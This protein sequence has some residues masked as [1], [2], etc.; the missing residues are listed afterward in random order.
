MPI[1]APE[2]S[3]FPPDLLDRPTIGDETDARWWALYSLPRREKQLMRRLKTHGLAFYAPVVPKRTR[4]PS[5]RVRVSHV[6]LFSGYVF[7]YGAGGERYAAM[8][9]N[10]VSR[11]LEVPDGRQ[12]TVDLRRIQ[13]LIACGEPLT[14]EARLDAGRLVRVRSGAFL[15]MEGVVIRRANETRLLVAVN[16]LQRGASVLLD[17]CQVEP[18]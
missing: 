4:A 18:I 14:P 3:L 11:C 17:D 8:T 13:Q 10:C 2:V 1:L 7:L 16:F 15:G 5:G 6:P 9:S 12:L